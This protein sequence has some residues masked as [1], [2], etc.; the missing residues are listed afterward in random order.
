MDV[1]LIVQLLEE[2]TAIYA[3]EKKQLADL[4]ELF[5]GQEVVYVISMTEQKQH[6]RKMF[7][8]KIYDILCHITTH[9]IKRF[10]KNH[11]T[12]KSKSNRGKKGKKKKYAIEP[13]S[14]FTN[15]KSCCGSDN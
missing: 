8:A 5:D 3:E 10:F 7:Y 1:N 2:M 9:K 6:E 15:C 12:T 14:I 4:Q 13:I 11:F